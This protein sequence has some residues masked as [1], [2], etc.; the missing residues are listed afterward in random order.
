[1]KIYY[2]LFNFAGRVLIFSNAKIYCCFYKKKIKATKLSVLTLFYYNIFY[3]K[4]NNIKKI[5]RTF[6]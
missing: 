1:M 3:D 5:I 6:T 2:K 4:F